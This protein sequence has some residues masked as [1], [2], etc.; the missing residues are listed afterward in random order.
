MKQLLATINIGENTPL[1]DGTNLSKY[2]SVSPLI[3]SL[4]KNSLVIA[5]IIFLFL[6]VFGGIM[7][8]ANAG[9]GDTKKSG[10]AQSAIT[11]ALIGFAVILCAYF[12]IQIVQ[13]I[14][15]VQ[16]LNFNL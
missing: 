9:S 2:T 4:L 11:S 7:F 1:G 12:I 16:I 3:S 8:I 14:T 6:L 5:S 13:V 10:Q 15:G